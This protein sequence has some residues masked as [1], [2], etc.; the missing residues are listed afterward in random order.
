MTARELALRVLL[1]RR[2][3][4]R[5]RLDD[6]LRQTPL[7]QA[8][9]GLATELVYGTLRRRGSLDALIA[10]HTDRP[11]DRIQAAVGEIL[12]LGAYQLVYLSHVP[13][14]AAINETV[15]LT[16]RI[17]Q[18][19]AA[20]FVNGVLRGLSRS[21]TANI[22]S[23]PAADALPLTAGTYRRLMRP[24]LPNPATH[25]ADYVTAGFSL[26]RW[27]ADRWLARFGW[28]ETVRLGF[29][30]AEPAP[31]WIRV[32]PLRTNRDTLRA[33]FAA[34][35]VTAEPGPHPQ[36]LRLARHLPIQSLPGYAEGWFTVQDLSSM[37]VASAVAPEPGMTVL[38]LC[39][40]PGG[41]TTHLAELMNN[42]GRIVAC[43]VEARRLE[44]VEQLCRRLGISIVE[45]KNLTPR[46]P[47]PKGK[48]VRIQGLPP[49]LPFGEEGPGGL[50][51]FDAALV[52][53]PC[54]NTG[55]LGRRP[56]VRWRL[57][58]ADLGELVTL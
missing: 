55:V 45:T 53:V 39:S 35:G 5:E 31:L 32:N 40:A 2:E 16:K 49:P 26:P 3:F 47:S 57:T 1:D 12:R 18:A 4:A 21:L 27:L 19:K 25:P 58:P 9:R 8:D 29:W 23:A 43:D 48:G 52:D 11:P 30:F 7:S 36:S 37:A 28:D 46:P 24:I 38:D 13:P 6:E 14:H 34:A 50:G 22:A 56:E 15:E 54:T 33:A 10:A 41:K 17:G 42:S 51:F 44:V 20:G